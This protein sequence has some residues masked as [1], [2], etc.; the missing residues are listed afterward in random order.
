MQYI[1]IASLCKYTRL[2]NIILGWTIVRARDL[3]I[4]LPWGSRWINIFFAICFGWSIVC[5]FATTTD[6]WAS[7]YQHQPFNKSM[8]NALERMQLDPI[9]S[10]Q[11]NIEHALQPERKGT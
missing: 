5:N 3:S 10:I 6:G 11:I 7:Y 1:D 8:T 2:R 4:I 9:S